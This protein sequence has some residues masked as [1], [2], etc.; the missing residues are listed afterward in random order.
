MDESRL[1][2]ALGNSVGQ[3]E[4]EDHSGDLENTLG[5]VQSAS[6]LNGFDQLHNFHRFNFVNWAISKNRID[7]RAESA[8]GCCRMVGTLVSTP[9]LQP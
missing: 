8:R 5:H 6:R 2:V 4:A 3:S 7:V 9:M 1:P